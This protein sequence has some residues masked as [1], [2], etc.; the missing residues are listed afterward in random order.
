MKLAANSI[1]EKFRRSLQPAKAQWISL[2]LSLAVHFLLLIG[3]NLFINM[4]EITSR[5]ELRSGSL[6]FVMTQ[7]E[8]PKRIV[9]EKLAGVKRSARRAALTAQASSNHPISLQANGKLEKSISHSNFSQKYESAAVENASASGAV[10]TLSP[11]SEPLPNVVRITPKLLPYKFSMASTQRKMI[12]KKID[13]IVSKPIALTTNDSS[14]T[15]EKDGQ[16]FQF[17]LRHSPAP[18]ST[19]LDELWVGVSTIDGDDTLT[20]QLRMKRLAFSQFAQFVDYWDPQVALHDDE[21]DGRFHSNST[22][23]ISSQGGAQPKFRGKVTTAAYSIRSSQPIFYIDNREVFLEGLEE[24]ADRIPLPRVFHGMPKDTSHSAGRVHSFTQ[25]SWL[26]FYG[27]GTYTWHTAAAPN[28]ERHGKLSREPNSIV[29]RGRTR[30]HVKG[31][32]KGKLLIYSESDIVIDGDLGYAQDPKIFPQSEDFLGLVST[33]DIEIAPPSITGP[34]DLKIYAAIL[35][36]GKFRVPHLYTRQTGTLHVYGSLSAGSI[37][38]TE[39][40]YATRIRFDKRFEK[41]RPPNFPMTNRY[42]IAEWDE[43]WMVK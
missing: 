35:A 21:F 34:G 31:V 22:M 32:I 23:V 26:T 27:D 43:R 33:K 42:E 20:T 1:I 30:L 10:E 40:R 19:G 13:E 24:G 15:L 5:F 11:A 29:G 28:D 17:N 16:R 7:V 4:P 3:L 36:K 14:F 25:E 37:T 8:A 41:M 18:S 38:A 9:D 12:L 2:G 39:P 6:D